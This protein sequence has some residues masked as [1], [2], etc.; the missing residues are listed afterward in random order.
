MSGDLRNPLA[1]RRRE[2]EP[3]EAGPARRSYARPEPAGRAARL[4]R[5][6]RE[7][8]P[9]PETYYRTRI[10][11]LGAARESGWAPGRCPFHDDHSASLSVHL[12]GERGGW[13]CFAGCGHGDLVSFH[14]RLTGLGFV[15]AV[16]ELIGGDDERRT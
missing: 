9:S 2:K 7:R 6:W 1:R 12:G 14:M 10:E 8:L 15:E 4:P 16:R 13:R 5:N 3:S 11:R